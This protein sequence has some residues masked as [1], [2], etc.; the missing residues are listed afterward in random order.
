MAM[1]QANG[2]NFYCETG[3]SGPDL[4]FVHG[5]IHGVEYWEHQLPEFSR[6]HR[7]LAY[8]RRGHAR[9]ELTRYGFSL[10]NQTNDLKALLDH[11]GMARP[12]IV[13][14]AFGTTIAANFALL[15]P[16]RVRALVIVA[17]SELHDAMLYFHRWAKYSETVARILRTDGRDALI[18]FLMREG[19]KSL[20]MVIPTSPPAQP[21]VREKIVRMFGAHPVEEY[22]QGML[23]FATSVPNLI[24][25]FKQLELPVLGL[26]GDRDPYPDQPA[27]LSGMKRFVEAPMIP[28][29]GR[30]VH[31]EQPALFNAAVRRFLATLPAQ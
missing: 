2:C 16:E 10:N 17:W 1:V 27:I 30:F 11:H 20:Y 25:A 31:W 9:T 15:H 29:A 6:D 4:V 19:G 23:E 7:V 14:V 3:G 12:I 5:E 8:N 22:E 18:N 21:A 28:D 13:A 26:C 24:P